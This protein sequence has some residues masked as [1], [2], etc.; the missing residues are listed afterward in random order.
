MKNIKYYVNICMVIILKNNEN[1][2]IFIVTILLIILASPVIY[3]IINKNISYNTHSIKQIDSIKEYGYSINENSTEYQRKLFKNLKNVL[4]EESINEDE[5]AKIISKSFASD[6][7]T[8]STKITNSDVGGLQYVFEDFKKDFISI[9][10]AGLY[11]SL[12]S[13][14]YGDRKQTLPE[15]INVE[16]INIERKDFKYNDQIFND[17]YYIELKI[18]Y[19]KD[20]GYPTNYN[21]VIV[22]NEK[23]M[24]VVKSYS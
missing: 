2:I 4:N 8:L 18:D 20:L 16:I 3:I 13:N 17:S 14:V 5:Y 9:A 21:V 6:L 24:Q 11:S 10:K 23:L 15:V 22:K 1:L 19:S 7:F 12:K